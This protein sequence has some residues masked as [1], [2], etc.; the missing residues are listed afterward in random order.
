MNEPL[1]NRGEAMLSW[2][3]T[4]LEQQGWRLIA[5][6]KPGTY[7]C[8]RCQAKISESPD[9]VPAAARETARGVLRILFDGHPGAE[10]GRFVECEDAIGCSVNAGE[11]SQENGYHVLTVTSLPGA[12]VVVES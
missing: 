7:C 3:R 12:P 10:S 8:E 5:P 4:Q 6:N 1:E 9:E 2:A 11:W